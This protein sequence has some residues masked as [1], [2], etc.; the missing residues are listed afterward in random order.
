MF[1]IAELSLLSCRTMVLMSNCGLGK[2]A[3]KPFNSPK[4]LAAFAKCLSISG[5]SV[6]DSEGRLGRSLKGMFLLNAILLFFCHK[7]TKALRRTK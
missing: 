7:A 5:D 1:S 4:N 6:K 3:H 2:E